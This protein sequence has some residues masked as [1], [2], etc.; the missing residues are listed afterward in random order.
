ME[1]S[2]THWTRITAVVVMLVAAAT[3]PASAETTYQM[4]PKVI[5]DLIDAP[6]TPATSIGP[7]NDTML[8]LARPALPSIAEVS[9]P[10]LRLAGVRINP[11]TSGPARR[12]YYTGLTLKGIS[13]GLE[14]EIT[15]LP[16]DARIRDVSW[17]PDGSLIAFT[18]TV[19]NGMEL[20]VASV[21]EARARRVTGPNLNATYASPFDWVSDDK[22]MI[23]KLVQEGRGP[24]PPV[25]TVPTGP[26]VQENTGQKRPA[27]TYQ[28]LLENPHDKALFDHYFTSQLAKVTVDG[29]VTKIGTPAIY[30]SAVPSPNGKY[31]LTEAIHRPYSYLVPVSRFPERIEVL[32]MDGQ[33]V[34][35]IADN[36]LAEG[37]PVAF[38]SVR[39]GPRSVDWRADVPATV[40][41]AEAQ[42]GGDAGA[43]AEIRDTIYVL[44]QP[45]DGSPVALVNM[46]LRFGGFTWGN[47][48][49]ALANEW[50]WKTRKTKT[51]KVD[52]S[53]PGSEAT[54]LVDRSF[55]DRYNDPGRP[56]TE[57]TSHGTR[58]LMF[59]DGGR[60]VFLSGAGASSEGDRPF[61]DTMNLETKDTKRLWRSEA[62]YYEYAVDVIDPDAMTVVTRREAVDEPPNYYVRNLSKG[63]E[64]Q[65]TNYPHPMPQ[66][67]E[68][69]K[70]L[71]RYDR[72]DG[73]KLTATLYTP[74]G[75]T[76]SDGPLPMLMWAYPQEYKSADAAGQVTD[77]PYRFVRTRPLSPLLWLMHGYAVLDNPSLPIIGEG[78]KEPN[79]T[80]VEQLVAGAK[81]AVDEVVRRGV[82]DRD[83]IAIG[84]HSYGAFMTANLLAHSDL[85][86]AGIARSGAYNR[87]LTPF[88]FQAEE[89]TFWQAPKVYFEMS[90]FMHVTD[91]DEPI[92][93]IHGEA[94]NNSGTF[95]MQSERFY[96]ALK[97]NGAT[98]KL[99]MLP[100][101]AH[102]YRA[103]ESV[104]DMAYEMDA[105]LDKYVKNAGP[106]PPKKEPVKKKPTKPA[107]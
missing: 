45:F 9:Q 24:E 21:R 5:A 41:W 68:V 15:G 106:R 70:E 63:T 58:V 84:G 103:R 25:P 46:A 1:S 88:G 76:T 72:A 77:S 7:D 55:E 81:A 105:W 23:V 82:A 62:P 83:R 98:C 96:N 26:I 4:P 16:K 86:R 95:P 85:F 78:D 36:P 29:V 61:L 44:A 107:N 52:P 54:L 20:W 13:T 22:T 11:R 99:V 97:G 53:K 28:D 39:T 91:I 66:M 43:E 51:W 65:L 8:M 12:S 102:G 104:M 74:P 14:R 18:N 73:V 27:R 60:S 64:R 94:D 92:L 3:V 59:T 37:V 69:H 17:S 56:L 49:V 6:Q 100:A 50:W 32:D 33:R 47:E 75:Y 90:P 31:I 35:L 71:I 30:A 79:D 57:R 101:E 40:Y 38:G 93:L 10:E 80:Y 42:D 67:K 19:D 87:T 2:T 89:R 34:R 48:H